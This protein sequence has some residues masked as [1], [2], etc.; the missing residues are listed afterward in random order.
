M[1][2]QGRV[3]CLTVRPS[4]LCFYDYDSCCLRG[5]L[6][7]VRVLI[8]RV[9]VV[10]AWR[11]IIKRFCKR[12][13]NRGFPSPCD[14]GGPRKLTSST[15]WVFQRCAAGLPSTRC[16]F[17][18]GHVALVAVTQRLRV[19]PLPRRAASENSG[20]SSEEED[21]EAEDE[22]KKKEEDEEE[23]DDDD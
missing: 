13:L 11:G 22:E 20:S 5:P 14:A 21:E 7:V 19:S 9:D 4:G 18:Q 6:H 10:A 15:A 2:Q 3:F 12:S 1:V 17:W 8:L 16:V 23:D